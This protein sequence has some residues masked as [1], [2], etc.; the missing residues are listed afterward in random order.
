MSKCLYG[1]ISC[2][3]LCQNVFLYHSTLSIHMCIYDIVVRNLYCKEYDHIAGIC[4]VGKYGISGI[5]R[6]LS[7]RFLVSYLVKESIES[8]LQAC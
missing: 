7:N 6:Y 2:V 3:I 4:L 8:L 1:S 5:N